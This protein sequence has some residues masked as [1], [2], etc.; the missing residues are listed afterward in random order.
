MAAGR[1]A[2]RRR[3]GCY[4]SASPITDCSCER[5]SRSTDP[6]PRYLT[7]TAE[8]RGSDRTICDVSS[9]QVTKIARDPD[10]SLA[11]RA[12]RVLPGDHAADLLPEVKI[13]E[14]FVITAMGIQPPEQ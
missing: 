6:F 4:C 11:A 9:Q 8:T 10:G 2:S 14:P 12:M 13:N 3:A 7:R 1:S 5:D